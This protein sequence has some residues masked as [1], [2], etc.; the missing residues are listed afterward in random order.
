M[1]GAPAWSRSTK[2]AHRADP[3]GR[4]PHG[5]NPRLGAASQGEQVLVLCPAGEI[6]AAI[7]LGGIACDAFPVPGNRETPLIRFRDGATLSYDPQ[8]HVLAF[9]LP[10][11]GK[12]ALTGDLAVSGTITAQGD[13][14]GAGISLAAHRHGGVQGG[15]GQSGG[16]CDHANRHE[17][18]DRAPLDGDAHLVQSC[19]DIVTTPLGT[20]V[21]RRDYGCLLAELDRPLN[22]ATPARLDG[23]CPRARPVGAAHRAAGDRLGRSGLGAGQ[24]EITA[25]ARA[26]RPPPSPA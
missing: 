8:A 5:A 9:A 19:E 2:A 10:D 24:A 11:G 17:P 3:L 23:D 4:A 21:M 6:G 14:T 26:A 22:R 20:R 16:P 25:P 7:A 18:R 1:R 12:L 13:V 15:S